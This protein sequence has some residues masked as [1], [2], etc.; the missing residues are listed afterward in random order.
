MSLFQG[1]SLAFGGRSWAS[2]DEEWD[3]EDDQARLDTIQ[4]REDE[5][6]EE[7][8]KDRVIEISCVIIS[9]FT[10]LLC[11]LFMFYFHAKKR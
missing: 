9:F 10:L 7:G 4:E 11:L 1:S 6:S 2:L 5:D 8:Q 3:A